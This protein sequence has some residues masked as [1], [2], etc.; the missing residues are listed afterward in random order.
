MTAGSGLI[1]LGLV[2]AG[3]GLLDRRWGRRQWLGRLLMGIAIALGGLSLAL[4][5][6]A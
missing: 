2:V 4:S 6:Q 5:A 3:M 1:V